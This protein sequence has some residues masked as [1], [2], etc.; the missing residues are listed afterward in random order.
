MED[1][2]KNKKDDKAKKPEPKVPNPDANPEL[3]QN[4]TTRQWKV[5]I[6]EI[7]VTN[8]MSEKQSVFLIF[9]IGDSFK[10]VDSL[11]PTGKLVTAA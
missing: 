1:D 5:N 4:T 9:K 11:T 10:L 6:Q 8:L 2:K 3:K 7:R